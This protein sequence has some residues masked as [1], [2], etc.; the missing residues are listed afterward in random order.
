MHGRVRVAVV[1]KAAAG[2]GQFEAA[3]ERGHQVGARVQRDLARPAVGQRH[4]RFG[5]T[6][7]EHDRGARMVDPGDSRDQPGVGGLG[8]EA[9]DQHGRAWASVGEGRVPHPLAWERGVDH[10]PD[11]RW[12]IVVDLV[13]W[14]RSPQGHPRLVGK[15][16]QGGTPL[17]RRRQRVVQVLDAVHDP[18]RAVVP[19]PFDSADAEARVGAL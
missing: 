1:N 17:G 2:V 4:S 3:V 5:E 16:V 14:G 15:A 10:R 19:D 9:R 8:P 12:P 13:R 7:M 18:A 6:R 11:V